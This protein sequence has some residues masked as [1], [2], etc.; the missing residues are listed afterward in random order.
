MAAY[1]PL[2]AA[3]AK[4][5]LAKGQPAFPE[6]EGP[7]TAWLQNVLFERNGSE[8]RGVLRRQYLQAGPV[9]ECLPA[10]AVATVLMFVGPAADIRFSAEAGMH[11]FINP[12]SEDSNPDVR[13]DVSG[14]MLVEHRP[15][16]EIIRKGSIKADSPRRSYD[17]AKAT[18]DDRY[19]NETFTNVWGDLTAVL[20]PI[21][22]ATVRHRLRQ[23]VLE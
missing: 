10:N 4:T 18:V 20:A 12:T 6:G 8:V 17:R 14:A 21:L 23:V 15:P 5:A 1:L 11:V 9:D 16:V 13:V 22:D 7:A 3:E 19:L 2:L